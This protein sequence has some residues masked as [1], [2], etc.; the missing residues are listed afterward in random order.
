LKRPSGD[1]LELSPRLS[2]A[3]RQVLAAYMIHYTHC[4]RLAC[5]DIAGE[6]AIA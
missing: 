3:I 1:E 2:D 5:A 4:A 6:D